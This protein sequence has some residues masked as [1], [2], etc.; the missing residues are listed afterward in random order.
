MPWPPAVPQ[1]M[2]LAESAEWRATTPAPEDPLPTKIAHVERLLTIITPTKMTP[3]E[4]VVVEAH[5]DGDGEPP[6][7]IPLAAV[8]EAVAGL[9]TML[10][11][12]PNA[13]RGQG[14]EEVAATVVDRVLPTVQRALARGRKA[15]RRA[16]ASGGSP[17]AA[18][19]RLVGS[20]VTNTEEVAMA[21]TGAVHAVG[22]SVLASMALGAAP[23]ELAMGT[24]L[25][26]GLRRATFD[27]HLASDTALGYGQIHPAPMRHAHMHM[28][29]A[30]T[31]PGSPP[32]VQA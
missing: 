7:A 21:L 28:P 14:F 1:S 8:S 26:L 12:M 13:D 9:T 15:R 10:N 25:Q 4:D 17:V 18:R 29:I 6:N 23:R 31:L 30:V 24:N 22:D 32:S 11:T 3:R 27:Q 16:A 19:R 20:N 5:E 2:V